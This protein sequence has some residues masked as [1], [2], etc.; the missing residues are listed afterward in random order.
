MHRN[1]SSSSFRSLSARLTLSS[2]SLPSRHL[3][4]CAITRSISLLCPHPC[5]LQHYSLHRNHR[6]SNKHGSNPWACFE[7]LGQ[8][9]DS[10]G[11]EAGAAKESS[12][13][14]T[15]IALIKATSVRD[16]QTATPRCRGAASLRRAK[17]KEQKR[18]LQLLYYRA[19]E[20]IRVSYMSFYELLDKKSS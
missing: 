4:L 1:M 11:G 5:T 18:V 2:A 14:T 15:T 3:S 7:T 12:G 13:P 10:R 6:L 17:R 9:E 16:E 19:I 20:L 8:E